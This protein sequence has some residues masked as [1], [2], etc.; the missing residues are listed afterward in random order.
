MPL[1]PQTFEF[2]DVTSSKSRTTKS[3]NV[4]R[5][6]AT[7]YQWSQQR[8]AGKKGRKTKLEARASKT[9]PRV[10]TALRCRGAHNAELVQTRGLHA[11]YT[12]PT[13]QHEEDS[14]TFHRVTMPQGSA[15][16]P[17]S[18]TEHSTS[19]EHQT[20]LSLALIPR[21]IEA[22]DF[23]GAICYPSDLP[24]NLMAPAVQISEFL[25]TSSQYWLH[26]TP[27]WHSLRPIHSMVL[28][29]EADF[30]ISANSAEIS[31]AG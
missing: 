17:R 19:A 12:D 21:S 26:V 8:E 13:L 28:S 7:R 20:K 27:T 10:T 24:R 1:P 2:V 29:P 5:S 14:K 22:H 18:W 30:F 11:S 4:V 31:D 25:S 16:T 15:V 9:M 3:S 6:H 23:D